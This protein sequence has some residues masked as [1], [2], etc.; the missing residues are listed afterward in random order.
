M[1][2]YGPGSATGGV[3]PEGQTNQVG[4]NGRLSAKDR[5]VLCTVLCKCK[6]IGV[7]TRN[8]RILRQKCVQERLNF[9]NGLSRVETGAPTVYKPE[10]TYNMK[11]APPEPVTDPYD[12]LR[13]HLDIR[14]WIEDFWPGGRKTYKA[15]N[16]N[17]R[18][19]DVVIVNDPEQPPVQSNIKQVVEFKFPPDDYGRNQERDYI[20]IA[21]GRSKFV[22]LGPAECG[23]GDD[24]RDGETSTQRQPKTSSSSDMDE[25]LGGGGKSGSVFPDIPGGGGLPPTPGRLPPL[26][27]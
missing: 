10:Q 15:G 5:A 1:S 21:G 13:P 14:Q 26:I 24:K 22:S 12:P 20:R 19:P 18:R 8:G 9:A 25:L 27:P 23:C 4:V 2:D 3:S 17:L 6:N 7:A 16:G 11:A